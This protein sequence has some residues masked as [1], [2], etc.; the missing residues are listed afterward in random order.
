MKTRAK[1]AQVLFQVVE[2]GQSLSAAL[3]AAQQQ[4]A[5]KD[6]AL[7]QEL[8]FGSLRWLSRLEA[9]ASPLISRPLKGKHRPVHYLL[10]VGLYQL[11]YTRIPPHAALSE[12]VNAVE[13]LKGHA[14]RGLLNGVLRNVQRNAESL[15]AQA[16]QDE[17]ARWGHPRWLLARL[18]RAYPEQYAAILDANNQRPPMWLRVNARHQSREAYLDRLA[19]AEIAIQA[20]DDAGSGICLDAPCDVLKLPGFEQGDCSVQ[21]AAAQQAARLLDPQPG[22]WVLDACAAPGGKTAHLLERQPALAG[23]VAVDADSGRLARV[24]ENLQRLGLQAQLCHGDASQPDSWWTGGDFDRILLDAPCSATGVI[25]RHPDIK[26]LRREADIAELVQLQAK[27]LDALWC[28]LKPGGTL[29]YATCSV[30]PDENRE[31]IRAFLARTANAVLVP[32]HA[33]D[34]HQSP[35]WQILPGDHQ[36]DG[37]YYAKIIKQ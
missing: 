31:Q 26:W 24:A 34:N 30:L 4:I 18:K 10:L 27:I 12:T 23:L 20:L 21:D 22:D 1:A 5:A 2:Q 9:I 19:A 16:D 25:R 7:L 6:R 32:L 13:P 33:E 3:P 11:L 17:A 8:C 29:L 28:K 37:F 36:M 14:F 35:G 15:Q